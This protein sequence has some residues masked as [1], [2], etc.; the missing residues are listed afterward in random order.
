MS[1]RTSAKRSLVACLRNRS[2]K[3]C[4]VSL[5]VISCSNLVDTP[6]IFK[7]PTTFCF[8]SAFAS[9]SVFRDLCASFSVFRDLLQRGWSLEDAIARMHCRRNLNHRM[10]IRGPLH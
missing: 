6:L 10:A 3:F 4:S 9:F 5:P 8:I 7:Q 1:R 2:D